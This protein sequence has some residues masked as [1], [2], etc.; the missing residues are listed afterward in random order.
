MAVGA[1]YPAD[2]LNANGQVA[3]GNLITFLDTTNQPQQGNNPITSGA[4][5]NVGSW[6][7]GTAKQ[8]PTTVS[9]PAR[10][11]TVNVEVAFDGTNNA[12]QCVIAISEDNSTYTTIGTPS[13]SAA[14]NAVGATTSLVPV[15]LPAAWY[16]KLTF[17]ATHTTVAASVYY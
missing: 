2:I 15:S 6:V 17:T 1:S 11:V 16:I 3:E 10:Q 4:L 8:N 5:P 7:S 14:I 13:V 9:V 12:A